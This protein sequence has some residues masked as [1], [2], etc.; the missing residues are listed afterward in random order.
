MAIETY[1]DGNSGELL[2]ADKTQ[3][4]D[5]ISKLLDELKGDSSLRLDIR[6]YADCIELSYEYRKWA[7]S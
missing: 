6:S 1:I 3:V 5:E 7:K 4:L 2:C